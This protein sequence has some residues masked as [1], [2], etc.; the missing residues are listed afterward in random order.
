VHKRGDWEAAKN[1]V[2]IFSLEANKRNVPPERMKPLQEAFIQG[3]G[4]LPVVGTRE[5]VVDTLT[6]LSKAGLDGVLVAFPR[7]EEACVTSATTPTAA[8][9]GGTAGF[10]VNIN[11][12]HRGKHHAESDTGPIRIPALDRHADRLQSSRDRSA[13]APRLRLHVRHLHCPFPDLPRWS[14]SPRPSPC[15]RRTACRSARPAT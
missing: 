7:Y 6:T 3:W 10:P 8:E 13:G 11:Q 2:E 15:G 4:G 14:V 1:M 12:H 9:A 5:Q